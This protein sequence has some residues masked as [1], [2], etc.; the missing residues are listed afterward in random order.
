M[1]PEILSTARPSPLRLWG[2]VCTAAGAL[3]AGLG[4]TRDWAVVGFAGDVS[5]RLDVPVKGVDVWEGKVVLV[6][7]LL[8]LLATIAIRLVRKVSARTALGVVVVGLGATIMAMSISVAMRPQ[9]RFGGG[10]G[11][12]QMAVDLAGQL[13]E[14]PATIRDQL[15]ERYGATLRV[16][17]GAGVWLAL[18]GGLL[19]GVGGA[20]SL[21][22]ARGLGD[23]SA[24]DEAR[25]RRDAGGS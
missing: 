1:A 25:D 10:E 3:L 21:A 9:A 23:R 7:A 14:D 19:V 17:L 18:G 13:G 16:D 6:A 4:A 24:A 8:A 22:W 11:L 12:D 20:L 2:F 15:Q 5:G